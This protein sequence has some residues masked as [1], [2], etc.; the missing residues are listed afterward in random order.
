VRSGS[1]KNVKR[2]LVNQ[3]ERAYLENALR[4]SAG[5]IAAAA[6]ASGNPAARF[7]S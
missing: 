5:N 3:F 4:Q 7:S 6:R 1:L 2:E